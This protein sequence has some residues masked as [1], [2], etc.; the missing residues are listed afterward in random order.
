MKK[1]IL[2]YT[3]IAILFGMV[4]YQN[5]INKKVN[6]EVL[7]REDNHLTSVY[8]YCDAIYFRCFVESLDIDTSIV[9]KNIQLDNFNLRD[10]LS[11]QSTLVLYTTDN[12]CRSCLVHAIEELSQIY[13]E[14]TNLNICLIANVKSIR[15]FQFLLSSHSIKVP[16][17]FID[18]P[19]F[20]VKEISEKPFYFLINRY[21]TPS[22]FFVPEKTLPEYT[23]YYLRTVL[24]K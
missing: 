8:K 19:L 9:L 13:Y 1:S 12:D 23:K 2:E 24:S 15:E 16:S 18:E 14:D 22:H 5:V 3:V 4:I 10:I 20:H 11:D 17:Y 21:F 7:I 6:N